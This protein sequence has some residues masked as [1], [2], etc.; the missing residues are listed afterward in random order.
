MTRILQ[1][2]FVALSL[3]ACN[4]GGPAQRES[5]PNVVPAKSVARA[6]SLLDRY[7]AAVDD[8]RFP[9]PSKRSSDL[10]PLLPSTPGLRWDDD[11]H[12]LMAS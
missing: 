6:L 7:I 3:N 12:V 10:T 8:A 1:I 4:G 2:I 5:A 9:K 11:G